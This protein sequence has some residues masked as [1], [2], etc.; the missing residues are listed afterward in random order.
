MVWE[1]VECIE[2]TRERIDDGLFICVDN[3]WRLEDELSEDEKNL[4]FGADFDENMSGDDDFPYSDDEMDLDE[5]D[6]DS[7]EESY[8]EREQRE[9]VGAPGERNQ[10]R[11]GRDQGRMLRQQQRDDYNREDH[12]QDRDGRDQ[13]AVGRKLR[14]QQRGGRDQDREGG[15]RR[16]Y[17]D[18]D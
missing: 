18:E 7:G 13:S 3:A 8:Y 2:Y 5:A 12:D 11:D 9:R 10:D 1:Q 6:F 17:R 14:Q 4:L 16:N 15:D